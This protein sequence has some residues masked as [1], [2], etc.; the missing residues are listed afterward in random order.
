MIKLILTDKQLEE[1]RHSWFQTKLCDI[2]NSP[3]STK[4]AV[5][6]QPH[7]LTNIDMGL[8]NVYLFCESCYEEI[9]KTIRE[10][11]LFDID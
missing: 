10:L 6:S 5:L 8:L 11:T 4:R 9:S 1:L 3:L 2:C 7:I